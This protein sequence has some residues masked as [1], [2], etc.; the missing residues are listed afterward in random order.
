MDYR[1][2]LKKYMSL[3]RD[4]EDFTYLDAANRPTHCGKPAMPLTDEEIAELRCIEG[5]LP[6]DY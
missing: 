6:K 2:L 3:V 4:N 1:G 5:E